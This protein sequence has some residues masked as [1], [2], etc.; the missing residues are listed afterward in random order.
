MFELHLGDCVEYMRTLPDQSID[1]IV[2]DP[3]YGIGKAKWDISFPT[4]WIDEAWRVTSRMLVMQGSGGVVNAGQAIGKYRECVVLHSRNGMSRSAI[5][6]GNY[7]PVLA[8]GDWKWKARPN[9]LAFNVSM[10]EKIDHPCPKPL[11]A[12]EL[13]IDRYTEPGWTVFDPYA[14][15]GTIGVA[16]VKAGRKFIGCEIEP[17]YF[18]IAKTRIEKVAL[19]Y[20]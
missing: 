16:C 4:D 7:I 2:T 8:C 9:L 11:A 3:P 19:E 14:G 18:D 13:L 15:S 17:K 12:M 6:F 10:K 20:A 1:V 5:A